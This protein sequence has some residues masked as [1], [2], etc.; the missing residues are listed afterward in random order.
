MFLVS[1]IIL[2]ACST[3]SVSEATTSS[4]TSLASTSQ[5][6]PIVSSAVSEHSNLSDGQIP[7]EIIPPPP[8]T[9]VVFGQPARVGAFTIV[10]HGTQW[11]DWRE[12]VPGEIDAYRQ[13]KR[14]LVDVSLRNEMGRV[15][16]WPINA[17]FTILSADGIPLNIEYNDIQM[18]FNEGAIGL[19]PPELQ[20]DECTKRVSDILRPVSYLKR[21]LPGEATR[22]W[23][24]FQQTPGFEQEDLQLEV[25]VPDTEFNGQSYTAR[26]L[27]NG[28][29]NP[30]SLAMSTAAPTPEG[31]LA[32]LVIKDAQIGPAHEIQDDTQRSIMP[33]TM[34]RT[35]TFRVQN[36]SAQTEALT[37]SIWLM[38]AEGRLYEPLPINERYTIAPRQQQM[39]SLDFPSLLGVEKQPVAVL[40][41]EPSL[42]TIALQSG[43]AQRT[44]V[45]LTEHQ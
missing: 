19:L 10:V 4:T 35:V 44:L 16:P 21:M 42:S 32:A 9:P 7:Q 43:Q 3:F 26:F 31:Q 12:L 6:L 37:P 18:G 34:Q 15:I 41:G 2:S 11:V 36:T 8:Q 23:L 24:S 33:C 45:Q 13:T 25:V 14:L 27:L 17:T 29:P 30:S 39:V 28:M 1:A 40:L 38:D 22:R 5:S 20:T